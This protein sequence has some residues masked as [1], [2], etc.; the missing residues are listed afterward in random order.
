MKKFEKKTLSRLAGV[1]FLAAF[2]IGGCNTVKD[3]IELAIGVDRKPID[4]SRTGVNAFANDNRFGTIAGQYREVRDTLGLK[5]VRVLFD[6]NGGVQAGPNTSPDFGFYDE[7]ANA[8]PAGVDAIMVVTGLP[9]WMAD[10]ANWI[11][12]N[13]RKTF[14]ERWVKP[15]AQRYRNNSRIIG[16]EVWN[17]PNDSANPE[18]DILGLTNNPGNFLELLAMASQVVEANGNKLMINGATTSINQNFPDSLDYNQALK[19]GG[20]EDLIDVFA[21][22]YYGKQYEKVVQG[23]GIADLL[24]S[25]SK[26]IWITES[27]AQG[28]NSQLAYVEE[29]WTFLRDKIPG[30]DRIYYYQFTEATPPATTYGLKN[31]DSTLGVSD[32]YVN[33][34]D[35]HAAGE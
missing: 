5:Y 22:H 25:F 10:S 6:W 7:L 15:V 4:I 2:A 13:P 1:L 21:I 34:R 33:L 17:E 31:L 24:G 12:G 28:V 30:I 19:D 26:P 32:L 16:Y 27:G 29:A 3:A 20:V 9:P 11:D 23:G 18:N 14:V 35:R 8:I